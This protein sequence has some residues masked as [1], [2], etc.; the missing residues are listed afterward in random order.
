MALETGGSF[1]P[2]V[3]NSL[4]Y[5][6]LIQIGTTAA[7]DINRRKG[8]NITAGSSGNLKDMT[9]FEQ[10]TYVEYYLE[11]YKGKLNTLADFYLAILMPVD[12]GKGADR[13]HIVF[14]RSLALD[15]N[16][17]GEVIK[18]TKWVRQRGYAAN[19]VFHKE[20]KDEGKTY[21][22]EIASEIEA[23]YTRGEGNKA[24]T[25]VCEDR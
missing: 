22:W 5:T 24:D 3:V 2:A 15:Y 14:D 1:N 11:P 7:T 13:N 9:K 21:V 19:P 18:N 17:R 25:F 8:T 6:G 23:W 4:G 10:L 12:C 20:S 16:S